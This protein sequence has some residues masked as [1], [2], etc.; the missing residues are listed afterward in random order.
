MRKRMSDSDLRKETAWRRKVT[1]KIQKW[2]ESDETTLG[3]WTPV[4]ERIVTR[5]VVNLVTFTRFFFPDAGPELFDVEDAAA[6]IVMPRWAALKLFKKLYRG[7]PGISSALEADD[8]KD[9]NMD[10]FHPYPKY[11]DSRF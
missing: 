2:V 10:W 3:A 4:V 1:A 5:R 9:I 6:L 11:T 7:G 8:V